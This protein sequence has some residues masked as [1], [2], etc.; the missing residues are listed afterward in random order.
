MNKMANKNMTLSKS[1]R[2]KIVR[3]IVAQL[4]PYIARKF[5]E[6]KRITIPASTWTKV[7]DP[8]PLFRPLEPINHENN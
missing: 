7:W 5:R 8:V 2:D 6:S 1:D 3:D 4:K